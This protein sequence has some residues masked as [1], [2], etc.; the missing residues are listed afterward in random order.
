MWHFIG[1][2]ENY[3][4]ELFST[5]FIGASVATLFTFLPSFLFIF[6]GAPLIES[7][8]NNIKLN[9]PLTAI[10]ASVVGVIFNLGLFF[11]INIV[12]PNNALDFYA[13][14]ITTGAFILLFKLK[15]GVIMTL[16][17]SAIFGIFLY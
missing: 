5:G 12:Y 16:L 3:T 15:I 1:F 8:R 7:S 17:I 14:I 6:L 9:A 4:N 11:A 13:L 10:T 2:V